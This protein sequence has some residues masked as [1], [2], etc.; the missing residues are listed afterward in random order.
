MQPF[1]YPKSNLVVGDLVKRKQGE[2]QGCGGLGL[3]IRRYLDGT[4]PHDCAEVY[5]FN[6]QQVWGI[7]CTRIVRAYEL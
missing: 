2:W 6:V 4:P 7:G 3:I 1:K 5:W